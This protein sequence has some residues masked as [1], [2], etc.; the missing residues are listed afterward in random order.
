MRNAL[1]IAGREI[2]AYFVQPIAYVVM[3][4]FLLLG[5]WFFFALLRRF[6]LVQ[7]MYLAMQNPQMLQRMNLNQ[8]VIEPLLHNLAIV[9]VILVPAITMRTFA[10]EKRAGTYELL[11]TAPV[12]TG[13]VVAG[14][15]IAA[16]VLILVMVAL[17]GIFPLILVLFGNPELGVM[18]SG[19]LGL[20]FLGLSFVAVGLFT[21]SMTQNQIIAAISCFGALLLLYV[22]SWPAE[23]GGGG[24]SGL[25]RYLSLP[26]H[27]ATM[28]RGLISTKDIIYFLSVI[29][30]ALFLTQ[31]S[32]ESVR[33]R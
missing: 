21:S 17:A 22:I 9:L 24:W 19:Y 23:T 6:D 25:L 1:V 10:E 11:L 5:G 20:A 2:A 33:W 8:M 13:E 31:R 26:E 12:R 30:V 15:F 18:F 14:K 7:Q 3:T 28:V 16:A 32:V 4:V 29:A 27:F